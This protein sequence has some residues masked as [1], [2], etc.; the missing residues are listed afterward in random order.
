MTSPDAPAFV[1]DPAVAARSQMAA[2][3]AFC[4]ERAGAPREWAP[5]S[6][7]AAAEWRTFWACFVEW[8][9]PIVEGDAEPVCVGDDVETARF[10]PKLRLS[11][12]ENLLRPLGSEAEDDVALIARDETGRRVQ[13]TRAELR[14][15]VE[16]VA[17]RLAQL[18][19]G[20]GTRVAAIA[21][22]DEAA[23]V[24]CLAATGLG[25]T[26]SS[27]GPDQGAPS[28]LARFQQFEPALLFAVGSHPYQGVAKPLAERLQTIVAGLPTVRALVALDRDEA[29]LAGLDR[30]VHTLA[31]LEGA[32]RSLPPVAWPRLPF[33]HP[34]F[35]MFSSG[36]TGAPKCIVH[37]VGGTLLEHLKEER[38]HSDFGPGDRLQFTTSCG[39]MMWNWQLS[40]LASGAAIVAYDGSPT[41]PEPDALWRVVAEEGSTVFGTSPAYLQYCRE[42]GLV[43]REAHDLSRLRAMQSTGSVLAERLYD[44]VAAN[45]GAL[46]LQSISGGT[47]VIGCFMLGNPLLPVWRG[48]AQCGSLGLDVRALASGGEGGPTWAA[49]DAVG[50]LVCTNPFPSRPVCFFNDPDGA[51]RHAAYFEQNPGL[52]THG[53]FVVATSHGGWRILGRSDGVMNIRGI[54]VGPA[55]IYAILADV[56][57]LRQ[58]MAVEQLAPD[59]I[60]GTRLV[61]LVVPKPGAVLDRPLTLRIKKELS[62]R[63]SMVH[64][65]AA[66]VA[67]D[68]LPATHNGK[69]SERAARDAV[70]GRVP[71]NLQALKNPACLDV[72]YAHPELGGRL[73]R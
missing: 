32:G 60:G 26:W 67:V 39:W 25:A 5:F 31:G 43:P 41:W 19:V 38:L 15:R 13:L 42:S 65:P 37:G 7:W 1:P 49:T 61:L 45:V 11:Y 23:V 69:L 8:A 17:R 44:W 63:A 62:R 64:V 27:I 70:N 58:S 46:P 24:A 59:E 34:L 35:V 4:A 54:R 14:R 9:A 2:F 29:A 51:R 68:E 50:E 72:L 20:V 73:P 55:E 48:E 6:R 52:W 10:F 40:V 21:R 16:A 33:D 56:D 28:V 71:A 18:G 22:N 12:V 53:D 30:P 66:I 47:D 57:E 36:T 3:V